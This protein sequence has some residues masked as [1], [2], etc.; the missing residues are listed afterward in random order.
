[1]SSW[2]DVLPADLDR[3]PVFLTDRQ[4]YHHALGFVLEGIVHPKGG[5]GGSG[6]VFQASA[7]DEPRVYSRGEVAE[8][9]PALPEW[10]FPVDDLFED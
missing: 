6:P 9:E 4:D 10:T 3:V 5:T 1:M 2:L 8:A 7:P